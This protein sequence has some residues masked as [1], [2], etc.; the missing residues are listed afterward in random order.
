MA[1]G[2]ILNKVLG[3]F[4]RDLSGARLAYDRFVHAGIDPPPPSPFRQ[5]I[6]GLLVG[7]EKFTSRIKRLVDATPDD[8]EVPDLRRFKSRPTISQII[9]AVADHFG[10]HQV[11]WA[12]GCRSDGAARAAGALNYR[13]SSGASHAINGSKPAQRNS[14]RQSTASKT[15]CDDSYSFSVRMPQSVSPSRL[16][17]RRWSLSTTSFHVTT[18]PS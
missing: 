7:S 15:N 17:T 14:T 11:P 2:Q 1:W 8:R 4:D 3:E 18:R 13:N 6:D 9:E 16:A 10:Y 5:A 12:V